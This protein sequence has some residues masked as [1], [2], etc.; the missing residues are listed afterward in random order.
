MPRHRP[1]AGP[2]NRQRVNDSVANYASGL[3]TANDPGVLSRP[4]MLSRLYDHEID[5]LYAHDR[6]TKR[7]VNTLVDEALSAG[8]KVN[9]THLDKF[10][11]DNDIPLTDVQVLAKVREAAIFA[12]LKG[13][14]ALF[15]VRDIGE[16]AYA[17]PLGDD[18]PAP[19]AVHVLGKEHMSILERSEDILSPDFEKPILF[20]VQSAYG[21][22][23]VTVHRDHLIIMEGEPL[24]DSLR[25][26]NE[27]W[28]D[29]T[30]QSAWGQV[31]RFL[32]TENSMAA[33]LQKFETAQMSIAGLS[34]T[35][36]DAREESLL[37]KRMELFAKTL[38]ALNIALTDAS[39]GEEFKRM[40][41][42]VSGMDTMWDR[43]AHSCAMAWETPMTKLFGMSPSGQS[44]DDASGRANWRTKI[45]TYQTHELAPVI[46][47]LLEAFTGEEDLQIKFNPLRELT[48]EEK[49]RVEESFSRSALSLKQ[50]GIFNE[51]ELRGE[52]VERGIVGESSLD[53]DWEPPEEPDPNLI[54]ANRANPNP[55]G[56]LPDDDLPPDPGQ[57]PPEDDPDDP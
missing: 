52:G 38:S 3:G 20:S 26:L 57:K 33:I 36:L 44:T 15:L 9:D 54:S 56:G 49:A 16:T 30:V 14:G 39:A 43:F 21:G 53:P 24:P 34:E 46:K 51:S 8:I 1:M 7:G 19:T 32:D 23:S 31:R 40:F 47:T 12:R 28:A 42:N 45:S 10:L 2:N 13:V 5:E 48:A 22:K 37:I 27:G 25:E 29:S 50:A 17:K 4:T 55:E 41:A 35:L 18:A 11:A 6:L